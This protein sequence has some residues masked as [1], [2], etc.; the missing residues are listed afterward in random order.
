MLNKLAK[1]FPKRYARD[2]HDFVGLM[3]GKLPLE[4][5]KVFLCLDCDWEVFPLIEKE[6]PDM[7]ITHHP[8]FFGSKSWILKHDESKKALSEK[9]EALNTCV[10]SFHTNFDTGRGGMNDA[11]T[12]ALELHDIEVVEGCAMMRG[13][14]LP[15]EMDIDEFA[16]YAKDKLKVDYALLIARG[17]QKISSVAIVGG[18]G[19]RDYVYA[20]KAGYDVFISG[21]A[22]HHVRR[23]IVNEGYNYL[24]VPHE[25]EKIF[26][27]QMKKLLLEMDDSLEIVAVDHEKMPKV[28]Y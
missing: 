19:S 4:V 23:D 14:K 13:G 17:K 27:P 5:H 8:F 2:N 21:D 9:L 25:V 24:D 11:L 10:Y 12:E 1:R 26:M 6:R 22:P 15:R 18:G 7:I 16:Q 3:T 28:I 20:K